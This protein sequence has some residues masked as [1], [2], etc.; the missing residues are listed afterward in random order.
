R[1]RAVV[2]GAAGNAS[3]SN[4]IEV[5]VDNTNPVAGTLAFANL[6]DTGSSQ[7]PAVTKDGTFDLSLSGNSDANGTSVAYQVSTNGGSSWSSKRESLG[8]G[9]GRDARI[10]GR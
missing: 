5:I 8:R 4:T 3:T 1:W 10:R 7:S 9:D 2:A 6:D